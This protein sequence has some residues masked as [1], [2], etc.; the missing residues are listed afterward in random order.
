MIAQTNSNEN[1]G[2]EGLAEA[3][4]PHRH[5]ASAAGFRLYV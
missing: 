2:S 1:Y 5:G 3:I 4:I